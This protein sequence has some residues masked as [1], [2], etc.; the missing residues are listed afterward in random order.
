MAD[1]RDLLT[2][3]EITHKGVTVVIEVNRVT[4]KASFRN[5]KPDPDGRWRRKT[6]DFTGRDVPSLEVWLAIFEAMKIA[7]V[8]AIADLEDASREN[9]PVRH[10]KITKE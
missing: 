2:V 10:I 5:A 7:T 6:W 1:M 4:G 8:D 3:R 9:T